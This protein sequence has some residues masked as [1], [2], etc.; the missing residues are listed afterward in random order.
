MYSSTNSLTL[1]LDGGEWSGSRLGR[2]TFREGSLSTHRIGDLVGRSG[3]GGEDKF[4]APA[5][6]RTPIIRL[7]SP[8]PIAIP[9][10]R[11]RPHT[12]VYHTSSSSEFICVCV[13]GIKVQYIYKTHLTSR[14]LSCPRVATPKSYGDNSHSNATGPKPL[15]VLIMATLTHQLTNDAWPSSVRK[16]FRNGR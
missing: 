6:N 7:S 5:G 3:D 1:A 8:S 2:F 9:T 13:L 4:L 12:C 14:D 11:S 16:T 15:T 10:E